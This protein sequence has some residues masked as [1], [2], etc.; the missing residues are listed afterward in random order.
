MRKLIAQKL[1]ATAV[2]SAALLTVGGG[3][4]AAEPV[5]LPDV[6]QFGDTD[7]GWRF[8]LSMT[9]ISV[10]AVPNLAATPFT[11]EGFVSGSVRAVIEGDG[12]VPV[13]SG[14]VI[15]GVQL[16]CQVNLDEGL[17]LGLDGDSDFGAD[18]YFDVTPEISAN[19]SPEI[20]TTLKPG[21]IKTL[22][23]GTKTLKGRKGT[24]SVRDAHVQV[25]G[26][27][28]PVSVRLFASAQMST[29]TSDDSLNLYGGV[30][31]L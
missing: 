25:D 8:N 11:R 9:E 18:E 3:T 26:C 2:C 20:S 13:N 29:D 14:F 17:D 22:G 12:D 28:G 7:D 5:D 31:P 6:A 27:G 19:L 23:L 1:V 16:G 30:L 21:S 15:L 10:N 24:I 4:A